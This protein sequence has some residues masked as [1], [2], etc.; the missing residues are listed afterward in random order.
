MAYEWDPAKAAAN[1]RKHG[2]P[3]SEAKSA[4][5]DPNSLTY[6]DPDHA[7]DELREITLGFSARNRL[8]FVSHC[9]VF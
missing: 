5:L 8:V 7:E 4:F 6:E 1:R 9:C 3:F 2:V